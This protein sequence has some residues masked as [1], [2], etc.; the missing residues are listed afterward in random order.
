MTQAYVFAVLALL[1]F[2]NA[3]CSNV[4]GCGTLLQLRALLH[5]QGVWSLVHWQQCQT[6]RYAKASVALDIWGWLAQL[7]AH[8]SGGAS[9]KLILATKRSLLGALL[10]QHCLSVLTGV[11]LMRTTC[12]FGL[13][14][15]LAG[16]AAPG[17]PAFNQS[18]HADPN[19]Y[20]HAWF[21][22]F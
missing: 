1:R 6:T 21:A 14:F 11:K 22:S 5:L 8:N 3:T 2:T 9:L 16:P 12:V 13:L 17:T 18:G 7:Y 10:C 20:R 15:L 19:P 4:L